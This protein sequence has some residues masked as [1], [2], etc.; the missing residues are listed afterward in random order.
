MDLGGFPITQIFLVVS[1]LLLVSVLASKLS[2][3][4]GIPALL[5]FLLAGMLTGSEG[6]GGIYFDDFKL[7]QAVGVVALVFILFSG[8][9]DTQWPRVRPVLWQGAVLGTLGVLIGAVTAGLFA[10]FV[11]GV[12][13]LLGLLLAS[14]GSSTDAA[15][16]FAVMRSGGFRLRGLLAP[17]LELESGSNDPMAIFLTVGCIQLIT[18]PSTGLP[19]L[20]TRFFIQMSLGVLIGALGGR[21]TALFVNRLYLGYDGLYPV[22]TLAAVLLIYGATEAA[23][24]N[25]FMAA[26]VAGIVL[27]NQQFVHKRSL[28]QFHDGLAWLM[29]IIMFLALGLLVFPSELLPNM[30]IGLLFTAFVMFAARPLSVFLCLLPSRLNV[31][32]KLFV[33]WAG[34]RGA[35]PIVLATYPALAGIPEARVIFHVV[36]FVV[37]VSV[38]AQGTTLTPVARWLKVLAPPEEA[39]AVP[40]HPPTHPLNEQL[41]ELIIPLDSPA[42]HR[43]VV[44]LGLPE[45]FL[46]VL[47]RRETDSM[48]PNGNTRILPGDRLMVLAD[49]ATYNRVAGQLA[50]TA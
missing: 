38:L 28:T 31:R 26:Y 21:L 39:A 24:G 47:V 18:E 23:G 13:L 33:S 8:G 14:I 37:L 30:G 35:A 25:G 6:P 45:G 34:L 15:A 50:P 12:P 20:V 43:T 49:D 27:G 46:I 32:E 19:D 5:F 7:A 1:A 29:Q 40:D 11:L 10:H 2:D 22:V 9:L 44:E 48:I 17:L 36:F 16:V 4:F 42:V 41:R 3:R